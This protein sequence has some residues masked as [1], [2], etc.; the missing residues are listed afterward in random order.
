MAKRVSPEVVPKVVRVGRPNPTAR[1]P[2]Y[3]VKRRDVFFFQIRPT[4]TLVSCFGILPLRVRLGIR[5]R[6]EAQDRAIRLAAITR[7]IFERIAVGEDG[8]K[9]V[10]DD[11]AF[12]V[13]ETGA[14]VR[15]DTLAFLTRM[16]EEMDRSVPPPGPAQ[17]RG[18]ALI[19]EFA[20]IERE[21]KKG[22]EG[23][24]LIIS[25]ADTLR[26][27]IG[28]R[29]RLGEGLVDLEGRERA[30]G[31]TSSFAG[32]VGQAEPAVREKPEPE[33]PTAAAPAAPNFAAWPLVPNDAG[34]ASRAPL[35]SEALE[36][37]LEL[38]RSAG[39]SR[40]TV[41]TAELRGRV[42]IAV[43]SDK[44]VDRYMPN[45]IQRYVNDLCFLPVEFGRNGPHAEEIRSL[46]AS[47]AIEVNRKQSCWEPLAR[48][49]VQDGYLQLAKAV[50]ARAIQNASLK[51][52]FPELRIEWPTIAKASVK[53]EAL[54]A[55]TLDEVFRLGLAS[56]YLDDGIL[57]ALAAT[58]SRRI[59]LLSFIR[60]SDFQEKH[61]TTIIRVDGVGFNSA[62][63]KWFRVPY[64]TTESLNFFVVHE[65][66]T[67]NGFV[68]WARS[69]GD[70]FLF[71]LLHQS[72]DPAD[73]ASKRIGRLFARAG[74]IGRNIEVPHGLRHGAKDH[75][76]I[77][78]VDGKTR[79]QQMGQSVGTDAHE[80]YG[81]SHEIMRKK[82]VELSK[83]PLI[84]G[85]DWTRFDRLD[86][87]AMASKPRSMGA[88]RRD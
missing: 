40:A 88:K 77:H 62:T 29:W 5:P 72:V 58:T 14:E 50:I 36:T 38:R 43:A 6:R 51:H 25:C 75:M 31:N 18:T 39:A 47:K 24:A 30:A 2:T 74:A 21:I 9:N 46:G 67:K 80:G 28:Q 65:M 19:Q 63:G 41:A 35:F 55:E 54:D 52:P 57:P 10:E 81:S 83:L 8:K 59:G 20:L 56:G 73:T 49:T 16:L 87:E 32:H 33:R 15:D 84:E 61:N 64:K 76:E 68:R 70:A 48:K 45:E 69:Q 60:G 37:Y 53:R 66:W 71:R 4:K 86:F 79:R 44:P 85:V 27:E 1:A 23:N 3:L 7:R 26:R 13:G 78:N 22:A 42:L 82:C 11:L 12:S 17:L 34:L